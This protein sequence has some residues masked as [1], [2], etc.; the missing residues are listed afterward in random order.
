VLARVIADIAAG[1]THRRQ[2]L[3]VRL[4][5][6][7][8]REEPPDDVVVRHDARIIVVVGDDFPDRHHEVVA[9][10]RVRIGVI[11]R[12]EPVLLGQT[13]EVRHRGA[14]DDARI[15]VV[16]FHHDKDVVE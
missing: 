4:P 10:R 9:D 3:R 5:R 12:R 16:L 6:L 13:V 2:V 7:A 15:I 14:A 11:L 8:G 1:V